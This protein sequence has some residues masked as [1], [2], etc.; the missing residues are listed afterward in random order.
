MVSGSRFLTTIFIG[1]LC[2]SEELGVYALM[3]ALYLIF[4]CLQEALMTT[5]YT[6]FGNRLQGTKRQAFAGSVLLHTFI[7]GLA[8]AVIVSVGTLAIWYRWGPTQMTPAAFALAIVLPFMLLWEFGRKFAI[9]HLNLGHAL[10]MD[11]ATA[12]LQVS[13]IAWL[14]WQA[15]LSA[16]GGFFALA[17]AGMHQS[18]LDDPVA[19]K[20]QI[21]TFASR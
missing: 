14:V 18:R 6:V 19:A 21:P 10:V 4:S 8:S 11:V 17:P 12:S 9:A 15:E 20:F 2:G 3:F 16:A 13:G 1:R 5:P 7:L